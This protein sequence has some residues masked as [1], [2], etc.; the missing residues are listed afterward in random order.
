MANKPI[1]LIILDGFGHDKNATESPWKLAHHPNFSAIEK[2]Y[3]FTT[4]QA[5]GIAVGLPWGEPGNSEVGHLTMGAGKVIYNHLPRIITAIHEGDFFKNKSF[6]A[7][8][9]HVKKNNSNLHIAGLFSS[10]SVHAYA[11][12]LYALLDLS[13]S[14]ELK[15]TYLHLFTD[16]RD[17]YQHEGAVFVRQLEERLEK[18]YPNIKIASVIGRQ[19]AMDRD[20]KWENI[21]KAYKLFTE[22]QGEEYEY[23]SSFIEKNYKNGI[24]DEFV[25]AGLNKNSER[26]QNGDAFI[27]FN[28]REDSAR[29]LT[30]AFVQP[31]FDKFERKKIA[32]L[33]FI[34]MTQYDENL[35]V[36]VAF[37][38]L[39]IE[40]PLAKVL[41]LAGLKQLHI[42]ETEK[43]AH[44]TY[45]FNGG[46]EEPFENEDRILIPS[47]K[48]A[49]YDE[50][51]E[52]SSY[53]IADKIIETLEKNYYDFIVVNFAGADMIGH[54]GNFEACIKAIE[55][56]DECVGKLIPKITEK[57]GVALITSDH[58][59]VEEKIYKLTGEKMTKHTTNPVPF[60]LIADEWKKKA[61]ASQAE[62]NQSY[63]QTNG[64]LTDVAPTILELFGIKPP[65]EM[66]GKSLISKLQP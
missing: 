11:D 4:L 61:E 18:K 23:A 2:W 42:A 34:T 22:S 59:N 17:A 38:P 12:H 15:K 56:L 26:I 3:P 29:E 24:T 6:L 10:G 46:K 27:F 41:S 66:T 13:K 60:Y 44:V 9:E 54:T 57:A 32:D 62:I 36:L 51:P 28:Y 35:P 65:P 37:P 53:K 63:A 20:A 21:E 58:G 49:H 16:G 33:R 25:K 19:Y 50:V 8:I 5:S 64:V 30:A 48:T 31:D 45:F 39:H 40:K 1:V 55:V 52:M 47:P 14:N 43:Y 7:A